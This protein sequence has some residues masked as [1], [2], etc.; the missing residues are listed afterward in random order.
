MNRW[1]KRIGLEFEAHVGESVC[2]VENGGH[3][4]AERWVSV[5][6]M[7]NGSVEKAM[8][9]RDGERRCYTKGSGGGTGPGRAIL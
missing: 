1:R 3:W 2:G 8:S 7:E 4:A 9:G 6:I 5:R